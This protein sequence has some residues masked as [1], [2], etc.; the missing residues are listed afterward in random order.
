MVL[1]EVILT[2]SLEGVVVM[3]ELDFETAFYCGRVW[4]S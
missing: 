3:K 2:V 1:K 4:W